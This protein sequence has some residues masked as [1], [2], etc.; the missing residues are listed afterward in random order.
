MSHQLAGVRLKENL[1]LCLT[2]YH[3]MK[4]CGEWKYNSRHSW[5][6]D[7]T[8]VS[9]QLHAPARLPAEEKFPKGF[10]SRS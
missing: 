2:K 4:T 6:W 3:A 8:E 10:Q 1:S 5:P 9:G 7:W